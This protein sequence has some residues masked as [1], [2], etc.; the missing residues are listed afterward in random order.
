MEGPIGDGTSMAHLMIHDTPVAP[1]IH[2]TS[3]ALPI[4]G[5]PMALP[6]HIVPMALPIHITPMALPIHD[7]PMAPPIPE[8]L[9]LRDRYRRP[10]TRFTGLTTSSLPSS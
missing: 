6:I 7:A 1:L 5:T 4:H 2:D 10:G 9:Q 8:K 3:M